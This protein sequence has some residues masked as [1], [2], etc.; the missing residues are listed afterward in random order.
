MCPEVSR[1]SRL[2]LPSLFM[3]HLRTSSRVLA[4]LRS[5]STCRPRV[6]VPAAI[7]PASRRQF[8][9]SKVVKSDPAPLDL[10]ERALESIPSTSSAAPPGFFT[11][12]AELFLSLPDLL[13]FHTSYAVSIVLLTLFLRCSITLPLIIWQ[14]K[15][16]KRVGEL[17]VP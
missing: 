9:S 4:H 10:A 2:A 5:E 1:S 16:T 14:R 13:P 7:V 15:R 12:A 3:S 8:S 6:V 11:S 17:V